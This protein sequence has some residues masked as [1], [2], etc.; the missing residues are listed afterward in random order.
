MANLLSGTGIGTIFVDQDLCI[1]RFTPDAAKVVNLIRS[2]VG[3][4]LGHIVSNLVG[5]DRM[6]DDV[7]GVLA[8]LVPTE[9]DVQ[10]SANAWYSLRI[11]PYRTVDNVIEGAV[12]TFVEVT[13]LKRALAAARDSEALRRLAVVVRDANDAVAVYD[14]GG[15][16]LAWN[17]A[18][19]LTYG[20]NEA[21]ALAMNVRELVP[22]ELRAHE[23]D[24]VLQLSRAEQVKPYRTRRVTKA[25]Q[26]VEVWLTASALVN[27]AGEMY[28]VATT[29]RVIP[30]GRTHRGAGRDGT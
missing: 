15:R 14:R 25:G 19:E 16:V 2:D 6:S 3:R 21:E 8:S 13:E 1:L 26:V 17:P 29:E 7:R 30:A 4:P 10:T 18:A 23:L 9:V 27:E 20:W 24:V 5:Y 11:R 28:A 22:E 12:I